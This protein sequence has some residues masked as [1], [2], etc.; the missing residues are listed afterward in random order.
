MSGGRPRPAASAVAAGGLTVA[1]LLGAAI[2]ALGRAEVE[3]ASVVTTD[4]PRSYLIAR[5]NRRASGLRP[6]V[7]V[8]HGH[9]GSAEQ[10]LGLNGK[11]SPLAVWL[12]IAEREGVVV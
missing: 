1:A 5:P 10:A 2:P 11:P 8:F 9:G 3:R 4:G 6:L 7:L 12:E